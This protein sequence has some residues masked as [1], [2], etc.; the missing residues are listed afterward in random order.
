[1]VFSDA[2]FLYLFLPSVLLVHTAVP[3]VLRNPILLIAS[4]VFYAAGEGY[5]VAV[6]IASITLNYIGG[7]AVHRWSSRALAIS[8][9]VGLNLALLFVFKYANFISTE[10]NAA[11]Q[12]WGLSFPGLPAIHLPIGISFFTFQAISYVMDV[13]AQRI[14][15]QRNPAHLALYIALFPQL[16]AGPIVRYTDVKHEL[17]HRK[18]SWNNFEDGVFRFSLGLGK[19]TLVADPIGQY[20]DR[21]FALH[22]ADLSTPLS[23]FAII[24][25]SLQIYLD[26]SAYS[27]MAIG[28]GKTFGFQFPENFNYPYISSSLTEFWRRWHI[29]LSTWFRDYLYIPLGGNRGGSLKTYRNLALVFVL[30]GFWHGAS[31]NFLIWGLIHG[32]FLVL[33]RSPLGRF[34]QALPRPLSHLYTLLGVLLAWVF[35]RSP[36]LIYATFFLKTLVGM[37]HPWLYAQPFTYHVDGYAWLVTGLGLLSCLPWLRPLCATFARHQPTSF[38]LLR[39]ATVSLL[40]ALSLLVISAE[41]YSPF[42]YFRF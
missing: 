29:S 40:L 4:L 35:F 39:L 24:G 7:W 20:V 3:R 17:I 37:T 31:F 13:R 1:M 15:P 18:L 42:L 21:I 23:W 30:C 27:D 22:P 16:I 8:I 26:F 6:M 36:N 33:E 9:V 41:T 14:P 12:P 5:Y 38:A 32:A 11:A 28:L 10:L 19:K 2:L 25:Y 34:I